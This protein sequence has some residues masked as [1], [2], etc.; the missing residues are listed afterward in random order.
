MLKY[1]PVTSIPIV[2]SPDSQHVA[3]VAE[4]KKNFW[5]FT[6]GYCVVI[7]G[8]EGSIYDKIGGNIIF[9]SPIELHYFVQKDDNFYRTE[10]GYGSFKRSFRLTDGIDS[11]KIS[12]DYN[13]G[14]LKI[15]VPKAEKAK[16]KAITVNVK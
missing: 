7:D 5:G 8:N 15:T 6:S 9:D 14:I 4:V 16:P 12:A 3:Y 10:R 1:H 11:K 2:F 13:N